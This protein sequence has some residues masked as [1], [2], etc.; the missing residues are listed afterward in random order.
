[1]HSVNA[2]SF[3]LPNIRLEFGNKSSRGCYWINMAKSQE[4]F[5]LGRRTKQ[6]S[7]ILTLTGI[8]IITAFEK[9]ALVVCRV[10]R[11]SLLISTLPPDGYSWYCSVGRYPAASR[12][13]REI[14]KKCTLSRKWRLC[15]FVLVF[16]DMCKSYFDELPLMRSL[17]APKAGLCR[18]LNLLFVS[19][20]HLELTSPPNDEDT[21]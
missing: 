1:M 7:V 9:E 12:K 6:N 2:I 15:E 18:T 3:V 13:Q 19:R 8:R 21:Q 17:V 10:S 11:Y 16:F 14:Q 5:S 4:E 20:N